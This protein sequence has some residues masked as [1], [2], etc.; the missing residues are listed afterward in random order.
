MEVQQDGHQDIEDM[1]EDQ[2]IEILAEHGMTKSRNKGNNKKNIYQGV[3]CKRSLYLFK[4]THF[5]RLHCMIAF[6]NKWFE[7]TI[8]ILIIASSI[9]LAMDTYFL[10]MPTDSPEI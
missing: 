6:K 10:D 7:R 8:L 2:I 5:L 9:K 1:D 3:A 4:R